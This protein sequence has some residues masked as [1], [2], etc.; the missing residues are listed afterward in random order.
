LKKTDTR[1]SIRICEFMPSHWIASFMH[2]SVIAAA[3]VLHVS[4]Y[5]MHMREP[6]AHGYMHA[7][8]HRL[9]A[10]YAGSGPL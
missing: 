9:C 6:F 10:G 5:A 3:I 2:L 4:D 1:S 7:H 8:V